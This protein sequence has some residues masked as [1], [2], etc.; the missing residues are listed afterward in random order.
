MADDTTTDAARMLSVA[1][2]KWWYELIERI[3]SKSG[4][5]NCFLASALD[6]YSSVRRRERQWMFFVTALA[7]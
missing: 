3:G 1:R 5:G 2:T 7:A 6:E 4:S